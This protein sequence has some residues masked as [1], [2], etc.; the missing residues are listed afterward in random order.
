MIEAAQP[1]QCPTRDARGGGT[2]VDI[3]ACLSDARPAAI[4]RTRRSERRKVSVDVRWSCGWEERYAARGG[5][6]AGG[7][8]LLE[9]CTSSGW[10]NAMRSTRRG[11]AI[12]ARAIPS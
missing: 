11:S 5:G 9:Q 6:T 3:A 1:T 2:I 8:F 12:V 7:V 4:A 10:R